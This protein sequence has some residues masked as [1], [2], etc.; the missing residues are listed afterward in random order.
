M[1]L[2]NGVPSPLKLLKWPPGV[3]PEP[4][5]MLPSPFE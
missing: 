1:P 5:K 3:N 2:M 4:R